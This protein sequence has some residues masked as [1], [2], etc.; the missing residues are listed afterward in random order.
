MMRFI[1]T[2]ALTA[3]MTLLSLPA[4]SAIGNHTMVPSARI[5]LVPTVLEF[6]TFATMC[7]EAS[8]ILTPQGAMAVEARL[9]LYDSTEPAHA[10][11][12]AGRSSF[13]VE[14][15]PADIPDL[16]K[17]FTSE[18]GWLIVMPLSASDAEATAAFTPTPIGKQAIFVTAYNNEGDPEG[19]HQLTSFQPVN[20]EDL[21]DLPTPVADALTRALSQAHK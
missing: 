17:G 9:T 18:G 6:A 20:T 1:T 3:C 14:T 5:E 10:I 13:H 16:V 7:Q 15:D 19:C 8:A 2:T 4:F 11:V 21:P 12:T